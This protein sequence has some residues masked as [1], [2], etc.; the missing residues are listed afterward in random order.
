[1]R[2]WT[3]VL[4]FLWSVSANL[5]KDKNSVARVRNPPSANSFKKN[6]LAIIF[7]I[8]TLWIFLLFWRFSTRFKRPFLMAHQ[9]NTN[10]KMGSTFFVLQN[11]TILSLAPKYHSCKIRAISGAQ[12]LLRISQTAENAC[13]KCFWSATLYFSE[14]LEWLKIDHTIADQ[15]I[16]NELRLIAILW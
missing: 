14:L 16:K 5:R 10:H 11:F 15:K 4:V 6:R 1:M 9:T 13:R 12:I 7:T 2:L 8:S 3:V